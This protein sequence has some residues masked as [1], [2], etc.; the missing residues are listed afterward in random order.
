M[1]FRSVK[2]ADDLVD[3]LKRRDIPFIV[4]GLARLFDAVE[5]Q[6]CVGLFRYML[7][8]ITA[9]DLRELWDAAKLIPDV[10]KWSAAMRA[11]DDGADFTASTRW[12]VYNI[13]RLFLRVL[14]ALDLREDTIPGDPRRG[15]LVMYQLGKFSQVISDFETIHFSSS[16]KSKYEAFAGFLTFQAPGVYEEADDDAGYVAPDAVVIS[17]VHR[18][19]GLQWPAVFVP[20]LRA[21]RFPIKA[22]GGTQTIRTS[23]PRSPCRTAPGTR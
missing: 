16:P 15:E 21:N 11:L 6:A 23:C 17:T 22:P 1:L 2:D 19:K 13:Q 18:S 14:E 4:K 9:T 3:E 5:I 12:G 8:E 7:G 20:F 10:S